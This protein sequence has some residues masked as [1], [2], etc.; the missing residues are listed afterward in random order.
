MCALMKANHGPM[1]RGL[2]SKTCRRIFDAFVIDGSRL[3][4]ARSRRALCRRKDEISWAAVC[5]KQP[6]PKL[7]P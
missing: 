4:H 6:V 3:V 1:A 2:P 5:L 7:D